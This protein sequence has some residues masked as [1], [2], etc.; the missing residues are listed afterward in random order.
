MNCLDTVVNVNNFILLENNMSGRRM[1]TRSMTR[2]QR[3]RLP[4]T[5]EALA[6]DLPQRALREIMSYGTVPVDRSSRRVQQQ[7]RRANSDRNRRHLRH[8]VNVPG[9]ADAISEYMGNPA[10]VFPPGAAGGGPQAGRPWNATDNVA[11]AQRIQNTALF[12]DVALGRQMHRDDRWYNNQLTYYTPN[13]RRPT[14]Y[15]PYNYSLGR[16]NAHVTY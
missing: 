4:R 11:R 10:I 14:D 7:V 13:T 15:D 5:A 9:V 6:Q 8:V 12:T 3:R 16:R 1:T 2:A